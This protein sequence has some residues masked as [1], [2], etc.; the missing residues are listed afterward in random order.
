MAVVLWQ[1]AEQWC[2]EV[3][4]ADVASMARLVCGVCCCRVDRN[5]SLFCRYCSCVC[6]CGG[7]NGVIRRQ[8]VL[9]RCELPRCEKRSNAVPVYVVDVAV[10]AACS[11]PWLCSCVICSVTVWCMGG[12]VRGCQR[13]GASL[14]LTVVVC[15]CQ[16]LCLGLCQKGRRCSWRVIGGVWLCT[17]L[18]HICAAKTG[19]CAGMFW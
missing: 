13:V 9:E 1:T 12:G 17:Y 18:Q 5:V 10:A 2:C 15:S 6:C 8:S 14:A 16:S 7:D 4:A 11:L 19:A 3:E